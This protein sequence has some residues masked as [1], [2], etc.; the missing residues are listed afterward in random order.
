MRAFLKVLPLLIAVIALPFGCSEDDEPTNPGGGG[1]ISS[2]AFPGN[3]VTLSPGGAAVSGQ[4]TGGTA[5][6]TV[7]TPP[8]AAVAT[9]EISG[10][11]GDTLTITP[12]GE[13]T[14]SVIVEDNSTRTGDS[15]AGQT[16]T[17]NITVS[18]GGGGGGDYGSGSFDMST[19]KGTLM[20][21]GSYVGGATSG[22]GVGGMRSTTSDA[23]IM[24]VFA[25]VARSATDVDVASMTYYYP[26]GT[27]QT[28]VQYPFLPTGGAYATLSFGFG[29]NPSDPNADYYAAVEGNANLTNL[30]ATSVSGTGAGSGFNVNNPTDTFTME[31][32]TFTVNNYATGGTILEK[33]IGASLMRAA[34]KAIEIRKQR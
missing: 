16:V 1:G 13:G 11:N 2:P 12:V 9:A 6:Y 34:L 33:Q 4:L 28:G 15:P 26:S 30:T 14:T 7:Q 32:K 10:T 17:I 8:N 21:E 25:Y 5:P 22:Q 19:S 27:L 18:A 20:A 23:D 24:L 31:M 3:A 29:I